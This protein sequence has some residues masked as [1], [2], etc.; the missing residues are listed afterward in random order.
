MCFL[1]NNLWSVCRYVMGPFSGWRSL[2]GKGKPPHLKKYVRNR[3]SPIHISNIFTPNL[4]ILH[5]S[6]N[7]ILWV[8]AYRRCDK[9]DDVQFMKSWEKVCRIFWCRF[10]LSWHCTS[11]PYCLLVSVSNEMLFDKYDK[12]DRKR[13]EFYP[14]IHATE[15]IPTHRAQSQTGNSLWKSDFYVYSNI[16]SCADQRKHQSSASLAFVRGI[17]RWP[18][19]SPHEGPA[20]RKMFPFHDVIMLVKAPLC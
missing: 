11:V 7:I 18:V 15:Q 5:K 9:P 8:F 2:C 13:Q 4:H 10:K 12:I 20:T 1:W 14:M 3:W 16:Y 6:D 17:H 19:N